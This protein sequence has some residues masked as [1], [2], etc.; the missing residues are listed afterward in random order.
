MPSPLQ[1]INFMTAP[2]PMSLPSEPIM[3]TP[4]NTSPEADT[5]R[6]AGLGTSSASAKTRMSMFSGHF[7]LVFR[8]SV[9]SVKAY[10]STGSQI[11]SS[12]EEHEKVKIIAISKYHNKRNRCHIRIN[13][14]METQKYAGA[15]NQS[16]SSC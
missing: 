3:S 13:I 5:A 14:L 1:S 12:E 11:R 4:T 2:F 10:D 9:M 7:R 16:T 6:H 15:K 8:E